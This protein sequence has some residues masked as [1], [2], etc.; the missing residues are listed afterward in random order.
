MARR[1]KIA[2]LS[3]ALRVKVNQKILDGVPARETIAW[4]NGLPEVRAVLKEY[5]RGAPIDDDNFSQWVKGG[6]RD[7]EKKQE[8]VENIRRLSDYSLSLGQAAGG[9][10]TAGPAA[11]AGGRILEAFESAKAEEIEGL[12]ESLSSLRS[13]ELAARK[14][15]I[16]ERRL[17]AKERE[18]QLAEQKF[19]TATV[20]QFMKWAGTAAAQAILDNGKPRDVQV[21]ELRTLFFG[22]PDKPL[23][24]P[25]PGDFT[26]WK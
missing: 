19:Q 3:H 15:S 9:D 17:D 10:I 8:R 2:H 5:F 24:G 26:D 11:I 13:A 6:F 7:W 22:D 4:L 20:E 25:K 18:I 23:A 1:G 21:K 12:I 14:L 16:D